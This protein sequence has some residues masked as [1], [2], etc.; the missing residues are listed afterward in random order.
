MRAGRADGKDQKY[1]ALSKSASKNKARY[2]HLV[3]IEQTADAINDTVTSAAQPS[4]AKRPKDEDW[5]I[6]SRAQVTELSKQRSDER[7][8][9]NHRRGVT[10]KV[11]EPQTQAQDERLTSVKDRAPFDQFMRGKKE[12]RER[13]NQSSV[14][15]STMR[16]RKERRERHTACRGCWLE[17][18]WEQEEGTLPA[19]P[20]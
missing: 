14:S 16:C 1:E 17:E 2:D 20:R 12:A 7:D 18:G 8:E 10:T 5:V 13:Q 9:A 6:R 11:G 15:N 4:L 3:C 19:Y